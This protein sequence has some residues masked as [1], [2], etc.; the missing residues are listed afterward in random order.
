ANKPA[1]PARPTAEQQRT[2]LEPRVTQM[3]AS[4]KVTQAQADQ[5]LA[6]L[7][8]G[9]PAFEALKQVMPG[10]GGEHGRGPGGERGP[11]APQGNGA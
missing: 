6:D 2:M 10:L 8:A 1:K 4:G 3:V 9:K 7:D 5:I 11:R